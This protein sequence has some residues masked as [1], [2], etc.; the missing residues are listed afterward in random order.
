MSAESVATGPLASSAEKRVEVTPPWPFRMPRMI[1]MDRLNRRVNGVLHRLLHI[2][3]EPVHLRVAL[4]ASG[5][6]LFGARGAHPD[7]AI[8]AMR[9]ALGVDLDLR[10][11]HETYRSDPLIGAAVRKLPTLR[12]TGRPDPFEALAFAITEQLIEYERAAAIQRRIIG[13]FGRSDAASGLSDFPTAATLAAAS[14]AQFESCE[15]NAARSRA[16]RR[17][18]LEVARGS[19]VLDP[20]AG[21]EAIENGWRRLRAIPGVGSWTVEMLALTGQGRLDQIAAGDLGYLKLVGH[22][23]S[24]GD[25]YARGEEAQVRELFERFGRWKGLAG[26]Y[27]LHAAV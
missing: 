19:I 20:D 23:L 21:Q 8:T 12:I 5:N 9:R 16:L 7:A 24:G 13:R 4:L 3:G 22:Q 17:V 2:D 14:T 10:E 26:H 11:F 25:P 27:A 18:A 6:V 1:G 15:L